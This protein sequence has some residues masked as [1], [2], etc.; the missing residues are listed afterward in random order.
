MSALQ[1]SFGG[2]ADEVCVSKSQALP[3]SQLIWGWHMAWG[4]GD[5]HLYLL[6]DLCQSLP[7]LCPGTWRESFATRR[8]GA[9]FTFPPAAGDK[10]CSWNP[11]CGCL[12]MGKHSRVEISETVDDHH[13]EKF[14]ALVV[15]VQ[16]RRICLVNL[17]KTKLLFLFN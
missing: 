8:M 13:F 14:P 16:H 7:D 1:Y 17:H 2:F 15:E 3:A 4:R 11:E 12:E 9:V 10:I 5:P 6:P